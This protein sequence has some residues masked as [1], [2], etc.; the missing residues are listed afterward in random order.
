MSPALLKLI[1]RPWIGR[2]ARATLIGRNRSQTN[3]ENGRFT[4]A[5]VSNILNRVWAEY[6]ELASTVPRA[7]TVGSRMNLLLA[8]MTFSCFR[9]LLS[10]DV[11]RPYAVELIGDIAW[12]LYEAWGQLPRAIARLS[13]RDAREQLRL[14]VNLFLRFPFGPPGY[15][16]N[17]LPSSEGI[18][19]DI[20]H[21]PVASYLKKQGAAD[22]CVGTWCNLDFALAEMWGG[23]LERGET[24]AAGCA[25]C[26]FR[27]KADPRVPV[28]TLGSPTIA[29]ISPYGDT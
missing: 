20:I 10:M 22:L 1:Y 21:C 23:R 14:C 16:F 24:L 12:K 17:R 7:P 3:F 19:L 9:T 25:R 15:R 27:F 5:D 28:V 4:S 26:D 2:S 11:E 13:R 18:S 8:C 6:D 29:R